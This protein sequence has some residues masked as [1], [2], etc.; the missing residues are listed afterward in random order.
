[1]NCSLCCCVSWL[2]KCCCS[3]SGCSC[4]HT[5]SSSS[6]TYSSTNNESPT[7][8]NDR[9]RVTSAWLSSAAASSMIMRTPCLMFPV[10]VIAE[11]LNKE[12]ML[13]TTKC[14]PVLYK[15]RISCLDTMAFIS[16]SFIWNS[17]MVHM[18]SCFLK[19]KRKVSCSASVAHRV[20]L[21]QHAVSLFWK[22]FH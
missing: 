21:Y 19:L 20:Y 14:S 6:T 16:R 22:L 17:M 13:L 10:T 15:G 11:A 3:G 12:V 1:M 4:S 7:S 2:A 18:H 5:C 9:S 8:P